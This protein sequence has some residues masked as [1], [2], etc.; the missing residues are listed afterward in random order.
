MDQIKLNA[1]A[2]AI[3]RNT[4]VRNALRNHYDSIKSIPEFTG[5]HENNARIL[6]TLRASN[7]ALFYLIE[8]S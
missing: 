7:V 5:D 8:L 2:E 4:A 3:I 6:A 1:E